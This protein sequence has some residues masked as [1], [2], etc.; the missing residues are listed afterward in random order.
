MIIHNSSVLMAILTKIETIISETKTQFPDLS[1][2]EIIE[3][4]TL[5]FAGENRP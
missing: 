4:L 5:R 3:Q 1:D 2:E